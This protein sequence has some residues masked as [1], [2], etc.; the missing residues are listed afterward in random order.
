MKFRPIPRDSEQHSHI[1]PTQ[2]QWASETLLNFFNHFPVQKCLNLFPLQSVMEVGFSF[3]S[4][5]SHLWIICFLVI[6]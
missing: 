2:P 5:S 6:F 4:P 3:S 1:A